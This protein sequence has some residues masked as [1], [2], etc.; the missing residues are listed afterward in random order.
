MVELAGIHLEPR[1]V[2]E[3]AVLLRRGGHVE[4]AETLEGAVAT[5]QVDVPPAA[6]DRTALL[7]VLDDPPPG[8][9]AEVRRALLDDRT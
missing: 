6:V 7:D 3:L 5:N 8:P 9:L 1:H 2:L 4:A